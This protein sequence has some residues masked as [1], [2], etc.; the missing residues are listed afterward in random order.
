MPPMTAAAPRPGRGRRAM[1]LWHRFFGLAA[2]LWLLLLAL[3]GSVI[4]FH[5]EVDGWLNADLHTIASDVRVTPDVDAALRTAQATL[6]GFVPR[7]IDLPDAP[8]ESLSMLGS[9]PLGDADATVQ[10]YFDPRDARL[11]G[12]RQL[13]HL[14]LHPRHLLDTLYVIHTEMLLHETGVWLIGLVSLLW[15]LDHFAGLALA[16]PRLAGAWGA[17]LV[18]GRG[19]N[20]RRLYD[21]HRA[22]SLWLWPVTLVLALSGWCLT[23]YPP[24]RALASMVSPVSERLHEY[25][26]DAEAPT[27]ASLNAAVSRVRAL[28]QGEIDSVLWIGRKAAWGVRSFD[29]RDVDDFGRLWTYVSMQDGRILGQRHDTG[30]SAA[31]TFFAW[32]YP[33]HSGRAFGMPGKALVAVAGLG[34]A[35]ICVS[36]VWLWWRRRR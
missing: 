5:D 21:L 35:G 15:L 27:G 34:T 36:G 16:V 13:G 33:L 14:S 7:Y 17:L 2:A 23:W 20:L 28:V 4:A 11:L 8:R 18:R 24:T 10:M 1:R 32:Q 29:P 12:W 31:D 6:T 9:A 22:P 25:F 30:S 3:T 19:L 26:P